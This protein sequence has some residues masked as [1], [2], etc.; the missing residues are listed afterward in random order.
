MH[1]SSAWNSSTK[2]NVLRQ[3]AWSRRRAPP[4]FKS[5]SVRIRQRLNRGRE[6]L[7][8]WGQSPNRGRSPR[9]SGG[10]VWGGGSVSSR[11]LLHSKFWEFRTSNCS[12]WCVVEREILKKSNFQRKQKYILYIK[13][14]PKLGCQWKSW[15]SWP[16]TPQGL[17][18]WSRPISRIVSTQLKPIHREIYIWE[19][20]YTYNI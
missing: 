5:C 17:R 12:I 13:S 20:V 1:L 14:C 8:I 4:H 2:F 10:G 15:G 3:F 9:K 11:E 18:P 19:I 7:G 6:T 16:P